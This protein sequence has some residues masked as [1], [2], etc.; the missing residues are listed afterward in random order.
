MDDS[1]RVVSPWETQDTVERTRE[2]K[3]DEVH[4][5]ESKKIVI[6]KNKDRRGVTVGNR[7]LTH[8]RTVLVKTTH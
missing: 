5:V 2:L 3:T 4:L 1:D 8:R 7:R 6:N